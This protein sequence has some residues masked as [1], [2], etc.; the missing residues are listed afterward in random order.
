MKG[1]GG[2]QEAGDD[3]VH[4]RQLCKHNERTDVSEEEEEIKQAGGE[5]S[6]CATWDDL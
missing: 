4:R 2:E 3:C 6:L 5:D 1:D